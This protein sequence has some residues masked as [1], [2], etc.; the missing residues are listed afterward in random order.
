MQ[1]RGDHHQRGT[2]HAGDALGGQHEHQHHGDLGR[3]RQVDAV[4]LGD[5]ERG[6][7]AIDHRAIEVE[8]IPHRHDEAGNL[9]LDAEAVQRIEQ[10][11]IGRFRAG[12]GESQQEGFLD[13]RQQ[14]EDA[15]LQE[16][17]AHRDQDGPQQHQREIE[18]T[19]EDG[20]ADQDLQAIDRHSRRHRRKHRHRGEF[21]HV[22][23]DLEHGVRQ[24]VDHRQQVLAALAQRRQGDTEEHREHHHLQHFVL[25]HGLDDGLGDQVVEELLDRELARGQAGA[26]RVRRWQHHARAR[27][28]QVRHDHAQCQRD[29]RGDEEPGQRLAE[30]TADRLGITH[31][32]DAH[33]QGGKYQGRDDHLDQAQ[34]QVGSNRDVAGQFLGLGLVQM[35]EDQVADQD[36]QQHR[37]EDED[38]RRNAFFHGFSCPSIA[39]GMAPVRGR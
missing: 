38:G 29:Q 13:Q 6:E 35:T 20:E 24:I 26:S 30:D 14:A 15:L 18:V 19:H 28:Q 34:E 3:D 23:G 33:H 16:H 27:L 2:R 39:S 17:E 7:G 11:G 10:L 8:G 1:G 4:G 32:G 31:V 22:D 5:E 25:G 37:N 21:H 9:A 12:R 36:A